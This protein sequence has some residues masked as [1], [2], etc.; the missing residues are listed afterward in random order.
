MHST[1]G[2]ATWS[3]LPDV[4]E[5]YAFGFGKAEK[6]YPT[7]FIAGWV[8]AR[9]GIWSSADEGATWKRIPPDTEYALGSLDTVKTIDGDKDELG[10]VYVGFGGS[11]Y[12][13]FKAN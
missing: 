13:Y 8:R 12:A 7:V 2:G 3:P 11:G 5:V 6:T 10:T 1:D 9:Y 4:R